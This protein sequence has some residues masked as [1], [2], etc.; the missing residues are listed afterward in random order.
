MQRPRRTTE[1]ETPSEKAR[2]SRPSRLQ[3][4]MRRPSIRD[5]SLTRSSSAEPLNSQIPATNNHLAI[6]TSTK[7]QRSNSVTSAR[8]PQ[9]TP[10]H[11]TPSKG[12]QF[13][14][15]Q[16]R[17][18]INDKR[19]IQE[20]VTRI[21]DYLKTVDCGINTEFL[22][23]GGLKTMS[24][25]Q[26]IGLVDYFLKFIA[27]NKFKVGSNHVESIL[28]ILNQIDYPYTVNKSWLKTP[29]A[30]HAFGNAV[31]LFSFFMEFIPPPDNIELFKKNHLI[32]SE[33]FPD[34]DFAFKLSNMAEEG[35][36]LWNNQKNEEFEK[37]QKFAVDEL[38]C[39]KTS[40]PSSDAMD[41]EVNRLNDELD[42]ISAKTSDIQDEEEY[43]RLDKE[44]KTNQRK[45]EKVRSLMQENQKRIDKLKSQVNC[46][47]EMNEKLTLRV[48]ELLNIVNNQEVSVEE[49]NQLIEEVGQMQ[50]VV[51]TKKQAV[52][53]LQELDNQSQVQLSRMIKQLTEKI[54]HFNSYIRQIMID[55][56][57]LDVDIE[58]LCLH[59]NSELETK[60]QQVHGFL[61]KLQ[62]HI[63][64]R[65]EDL[66]KNIDA[67]EKQIKLISYEISN[68]IEPKS[69]ENMQIIK[70]KQIKLDDLDR[71]IIG[72]K[73][74]TTNRLNELHQ[75][76]KES[77]IVLNSLKDSIEKKR[78]EIPK[79]TEENKAM[80]KLVEE[81]FDEYFTNKDA[82][83]NQFHEACQRLKKKI[84]E[85]E[86]IMKI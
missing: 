13:T 29:T 11:I 4:P 14:G 31:M 42:A 7:R 52:C 33:E 61:K 54:A 41:D 15:E 19:W 83:L 24:M 40:I 17:A 36:S 2:Q 57:D 63:S 22:S 79:T 16:Q 26:F 34:M 84:A 18:A 76:Y 69:K 8:T 44:V 78:E 56:K 28:K 60:I 59:Q 64:N 46:Q 80:M 65:I 37:L 20:Q 6:P 72:V 85:A 30:P 82:L 47:R 3:Q 25:K 81:R 70:E 48:E 10:T 53:D 55:F 45:I 39:K 32:V 58:S 5:G 23:R 77:E 74:F 71:E 38:I 51:R 67:F 43:F 66:T 86:V 50:H 35:F 9:R 62:R 75:K 21:T 68:W 12:S 73:N 49:R 1:Y 27:G